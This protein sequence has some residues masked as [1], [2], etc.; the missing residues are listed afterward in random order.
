MEYTA[1]IEKTADGGILLPTLT[2]FSVS[3]PLDP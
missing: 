3:F 2:V 1:I